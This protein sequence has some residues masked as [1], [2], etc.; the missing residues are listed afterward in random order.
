M[1]TLTAVAARPVPGRVL[2][3]VQFAL[4]AAYVLALGIA[5]ARAAVF[6]GHLYLPV[7]NDQYTANAD[8]WPG[9]WYAVWWVLLIALGFLPVVALA[10]TLVSLVR[11]ATARLRSE[12]GSLR[13]LMLG[14]LCSVAVMGFSLTP[15]ARTIVDWLID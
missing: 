14:A 8:L 1:T 5:F 3:R 15:T 11:L 4:A 7:A 13:P 12:P 6:A 2:A 9:A 10:A